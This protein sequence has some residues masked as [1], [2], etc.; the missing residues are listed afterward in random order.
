MGPA[1]PRPDAFG[2][3][4]RR[5]TEINQRCGHESGKFARIRDSKRVKFVKPFKIFADYQE[6]DEPLREASE[7]VYR[8]EAAQVVPAGGGN[9]D[10]GPQDGTVD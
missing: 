1:S 6:K 10:R 4:V 3:G 5:A 9:F 8:R 2:Q 7:E